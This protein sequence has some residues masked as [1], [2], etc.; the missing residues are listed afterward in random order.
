MAKPAKQDNGDLF[1]VMKAGRRLALGLIAR[2]G[3]RIIKLGYFFPPSV[4]SDVSCVDHLVLSRQD[5]VHVKVFGALGLNNGNWPVIGKLKGFS[6]E[7]WP[8]PVFERVPSGTDRRMISMY[9][10]DKLERCIFD[11][12]ASQLP[13]GFDLSFVIPDGLA[14]AQF[15]ENILERMQL[16]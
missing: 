5:A 10:E 11:S 4:L 3:K 7:A 8:M 14:G 15:L 2:G 13:K 6:R 16:K 12:P 1:W 9:D